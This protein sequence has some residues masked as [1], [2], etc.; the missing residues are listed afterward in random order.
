MSTD[1]WGLDS[2]ILRSFDMAAQYL[3]TMNSLAKE[4][5]RDRETGSVYQ[6]EENGYETGDTGILLSHGVGQGADDFE[7]YEEMFLENGYNPGEVKSISHRSNNP[8]IKGGSECLSQFFED[9]QDDT[10][11]ESFVVIG[12]SQ[13]AAIAHWLDLA[14]DTEKLDLVIGFSA[15]NN[16]SMY[17]DVLRYTP[18]PYMKDLSRRSA[19]K[20]ILSDMDPANMEADHVTVT[21]SYDGLF[22]PFNW[23][24]PRL[25]DAV[26]VVMRGGHGVKSSSDAKELAHK[27]V[28]AESIENFQ[29]EI[30][31][32]DRVKEIL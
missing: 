10:G 25:E 8:T 6:P 21:G 20:G 1:P 2:S 19:D 14:N 9:W 16:G 31:E 15:P 11:I 18:A 4:P 32:L 5:S 12:E 22:T 28:E 3:R 30:Q 27:A 29:Q 17:N 13:G 24:S 7:E 26:N 23:D